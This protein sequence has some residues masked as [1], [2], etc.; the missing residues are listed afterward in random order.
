MLYKTLTIKPVGRDERYEATRNSVPSRSLQD[1]ITRTTTGWFS[2]LMQGQTKILHGQISPGYRRGRLAI[3]G[4][5]LRP[6]GEP[7]LERG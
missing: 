5:L 2:R 6:L 1:C 4:L 3:D 7:R